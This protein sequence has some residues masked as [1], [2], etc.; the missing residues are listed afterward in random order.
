MPIVQLDATFVATASCPPGK[1]KIDFY[2]DTLPG[3]LLEV[4]A[5]GGC[6]YYQRYHDQAGRLKAYKIG[7][8]ADI[9]FDKARKL[10][11]KIRSRAVV[12]EDPVEAKREQRA[13]PT[14]GAFAS[15]YLYHIATYQRSPETTERYMRKHIL[16]RWGKVGLPNSASIGLQRLIDTMARTD[17]LFWGPRPGLFLPQVFASIG[18]TD[19]FDEHALSLAALCR[20]TGQRSNQLGQ[21]RKSIAARIEGRPICCSLSKLRKAGKTSFIALRSLPGVTEELH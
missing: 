15:R 16:P 13:V 4:R 10:A 6:T 3:F 19:A 20:E 12:G 17:L 7:S 2:S 1:R 21:S 8:A 11:M 14:Y 18:S 9:T 5:S